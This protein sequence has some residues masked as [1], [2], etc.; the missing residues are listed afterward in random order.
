MRSFHAHARQ[1]L[2]DIYFDLR[3]Y[4]IAHP[5]SKSTLSHIQP[6]F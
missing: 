3:P 6:F 1:W 2:Y 4:L 5:D